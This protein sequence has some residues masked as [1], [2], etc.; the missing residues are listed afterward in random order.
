M[1]SKVF[2]IKANLLAL[3]NSSLDWVVFYTKLLYIENFLLPVGLVIMGYSVIGGL[4]LSR[5]YIERF[6]YMENF[7]R[8]CCIV[9][10]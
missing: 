9:L 4:V 8:S 7:G 10:P 5:N 1:I 3:L 2:V 6:I